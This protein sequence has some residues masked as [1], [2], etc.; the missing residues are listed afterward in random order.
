MAFQNNQ[1]FAG[2]ANSLPEWSNLHMNKLEYL[3]LAGLFQASLMFSGKA[4]SLRE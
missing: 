2:K 3:S 4:R 1:M